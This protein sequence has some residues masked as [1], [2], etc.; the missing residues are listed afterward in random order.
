MLVYRISSKQYA[1]DLSGE[2]SRIYGGRW[3]PVGRPVVYTSES[4][5]LAMLEM[6]A[7][8]AVSGAPPDLVLVAIEIPDRATIEKPDMADLPA[9]WNARPQ[10]P[11]TSN[12]GSLWLDTSNAS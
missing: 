1:Y 9:D 4:A 5:S 3:N 2:G 11:S 12:F 6:L 7:F 10:R 8:Y